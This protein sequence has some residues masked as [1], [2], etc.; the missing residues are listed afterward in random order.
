MRKTIHSIHVPHWKNTAESVPIRMPIPSVVTIPMSMHIGAPAKLVVQKGDE[1][2]VGQKIGEAD[3][4]LSSPVFSSVSGK[5]V[6]IEDFQM[7]NGKICPMA[8]IESDGRQTLADTIKIPELTDFQS[9]IDM[10]RESGA[11]GL[12]GAGFP[13]AVK[14]N[15]DPSR[16]EYIIVNG[17]ECEPYITSDTHIMVDKAE[18]LFVGIKTIQRFFPKAHFL[19]G[20]EDNKPEAIRMMKRYTERIDR[21]DVVKVPSSYPQ[22][23]EKTLV[24][25]VAHRIIPEGKLPI[26]I[27]CI[28]MNTT[29]VATIGKY[30]MTGIP[31]ITKC[32]TVDGSA[33]RSPQNIIVSIGTKI[34]DLIDFIGGLREEP[35]KILYGGPMMGIAI[36]DID[37]PVMKTTNAVIALTDKN[38]HIPEPTPC[39]HC[40]KCVDACP[41]HLMPTELEHARE[42]GDVEALKKHHVLLCIECGSCAFVCPAKR[43]LVESHKLAK[44]MVREAKK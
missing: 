3:G 2:K 33:I 26:D 41:M 34:S 43:I 4:P 38:A 23:S 44:A 5:V 39:I 20:I 10:V 21:C 1:V 9:F 16:V 42:R 17:A 35:R 19:V 29:T 14:L 24:F 31:L 36:P 25:N 18:R 37:Y 22:G 40:G 28:V 32:V 30:M 6:R 8:V 27:G 12:G 13:T 15:V 7:A 11:V